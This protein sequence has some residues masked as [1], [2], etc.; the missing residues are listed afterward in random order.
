M[1]SNTKKAPLHKLYD[2]EK[3]LEYIYNRYTRIKEKDRKANY[4]VTKR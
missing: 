3:S 1:A 2:P 4:F